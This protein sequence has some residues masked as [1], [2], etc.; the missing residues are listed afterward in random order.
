[1]MWKN[2]NYEENNIE[3][4]RKGQSLLVLDKYVLF[5][6]YIVVNNKDD[7]IKYLCQ[8]LMILHYYRKLI[9]KI[10]TIS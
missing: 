3:Q 4:S 7:N 2:W 1:M 8:K 5:K 9:L 10:H 6:P